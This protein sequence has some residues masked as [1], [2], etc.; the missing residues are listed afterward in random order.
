MLKEMGEKENLP[1]SLVRNLVS[2]SFGVLVEQEDRMNKNVSVALAEMQHIKARQEKL[3]AVLRQ[4]NLR[5]Q[6]IL[7]K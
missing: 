7:T 6:A 1:I 2:E 3:E 5:H 4:N